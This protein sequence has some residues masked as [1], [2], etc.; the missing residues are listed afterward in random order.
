[1][2][3][4]LIVYL[5]V[6]ALYFKTASDRAIAA[7]AAADRRAACVEAAQYD[8]APRDSLALAEALCSR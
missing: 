6:V 5:L 4:V 1:M 7:E 3:L 8:A 2:R